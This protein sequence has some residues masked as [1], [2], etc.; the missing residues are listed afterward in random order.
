M[1]SPDSRSVDRLSDV[2]SLW[3]TT[4]E[5]LCAPLQRLPARQLTIFCSYGGVDMTGQLY[6]DGGLQCLAEVP[7]WQRHMECA[8]SVP[9]YAFLAYSGCRII[10][11]SV[12]EG[13]AEMSQS[14]RLQHFRSDAWLAVLLAFVLGWE[15]VSVPS[16]LPL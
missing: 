6:G 15:F 3:S 8:V 2:M 9:V 7:L 13:M 11:T 12:E 5:L 16:S 10:K 14:N 4:R 1:P